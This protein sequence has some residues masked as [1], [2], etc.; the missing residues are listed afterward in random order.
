MQKALE[1]DP[2]KIELHQEIGSAYEGMND[3][4]NAIANFSLYIQKAP[5]DQVQ[6]ADYFNLGKAAYYAGSEMDTTAADYQAKKAAY[7]AKADSMFS[8]V[9]EKVPDSYLGHFWRARVNSALDPETD[10]GLAKPFY[11]KTIEV[12]DAKGDGDPRIY[13]ECYSYL[14]YYYYVKEDI[15]NS[16]IYWEKILAIDPTNEIANRAMS[17]LK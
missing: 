11:E 4:D 1:L 3:Y 9:A 10:K 12:L 17:G 8:F 7:F 2:G 5:E 16:K 6:V 15:E 14:G 13:I